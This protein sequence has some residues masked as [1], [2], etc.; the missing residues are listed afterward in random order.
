[1]KNLR[2]LLPLFWLG[3]L[4][5]AWPARVEARKKHKGQPTPA[6]LA[7]PSAEPP[8]L[9]PEAAPQVNPN[10][11]PSA[12]LQ[13]FLDTHLGTILAPLGVSA[14]AQ[15]EL[16]ASLKAGYADAMAAAPASH[17]PA[18]ALAQAVCDALTGA[19]GERQNAVS[20]MRGALATRS[21]EAVQ[22]RGG[23]EAVASA[24][25][26]D[27]FFIESAK[28]NWTQR[29]TVLRQSITAIYLRERAIERQI[30][31]WNPPAAPAP[32]PASAPSGPAAA[33]APAPAPAPPVKSA[34]PAG[35]AAPA[36]PAASP[37]GVP[38]QSAAAAPAAPSAVEQAAA[39]LAVANPPVSALAA[40]SPAPV[41]EGPSRGW[42]PVVGPWLLEG[43]SK[44]TLGADHLISGDRHGSW[45]YTMTTG[46][47]RNYELHWHPPKDWVDYVV[48]SSD[49]RTL[50]G[51][52]R[53]NGAITYFRP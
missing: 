44:L 9:P 35:Y 4:L 34:A 8:P 53:K 24:R 28:N 5:L 21:T 29:A 25:D 13:P 47:G 17:K 14:F 1:M 11:P 16:L 33:L 52:T 19:M 36:A 22:P 38:A 2:R 39:T 41:P 23:G 43:R 30:G 6:P 37:V 48:L 46:V 45:R 32:A 20:A 7:T 42:D 26:T 40:A 50:D 10:A 18:F 49:G 3:V 15:S 31:V 27:D 12:S 51:K